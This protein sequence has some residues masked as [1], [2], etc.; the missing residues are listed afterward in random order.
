MKRAIYKD[1]VSWKNKRI[2]APLILRGARQVGKSYVLREFG[3]NEFVNYH[4]FD[5]E[6]DE[7]ENVYPT[8]ARS[9]WSRGYP[10]LKSSAT[11]NVW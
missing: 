10:F 9:S 11:L 5:F 1:L 6:K 2:R 3:K 4:H 7:K 8:C